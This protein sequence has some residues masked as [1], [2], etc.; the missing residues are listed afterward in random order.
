MR[1]S[2]PPRLHRL[3]QWTDQI[4]VPAPSDLSLSEVAGK[5]PLPTIIVTPCAPS[6][7][8]DF[9]LA[10]IPSPPKPSFRE[11]LQSYSYAP[12]SNSTLRVR[13][14]LCALLLLFFVCQLLASRLVHRYPR[15]DFTPGEVEAGGDH[16]HHRHQSLLEWA[17]FWPRLDPEGDER[18]SEFDGG[19]GGGWLD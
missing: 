8:H 4:L 11:R 16:H 17:K 9:S 6:S 13:S 10:F 5:S 1:R 2:V 7:E 3:P 12:A 18:F 14:V 15:L 19:V